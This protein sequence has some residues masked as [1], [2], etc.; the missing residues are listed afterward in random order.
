MGLKVI[1]AGFGRTGTLSLKAALEILGFMKTHHMLE[2]LPSSKQTN[3]WYDIGKGLPPD[4]DEVFEGYQACVDFPASSYYKELQAH[5]PDAKVILTIRDVDKWYNSTLNTIYRLANIVPKWVR[6]LIP[7]VHKSHELAQGNVW[8]K[9]FEGRFEDEA[10]AKQVFLNHIAAVEANVSE[11]KL[12]IFEVSQGW[13]PL[14]TFLDVPV[15][16]R[17]FPRLNDT[18]SVQRALTLMRTLFITVPVILVAGIAYAIY[19][20]FSI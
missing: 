10:Y 6:I 9:I 7:R 15:P 3:L 17:P 16:D 14:C 12:L 18:A 5:Y 13:E 20:A 1:G 2:V 19:A 11:D 4:W 8:N